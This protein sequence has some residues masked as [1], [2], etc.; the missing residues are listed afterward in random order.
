MAGS[1]GIRAWQ[2]IAKKL[3]SLAISQ[4]SFAAPAPVEDR[5]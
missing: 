5:P 2:N 3:T 1:T 4:A